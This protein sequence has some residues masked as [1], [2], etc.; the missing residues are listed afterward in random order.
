MTLENSS[1]FNAFF[2]TDTHATSV[3]Y[4]PNGG[5]SSNINVIF[6]NEFNLVDA[7]EV[8]VES[9]TPVVTCKS[10][11][12]PN[13]QQGDQFTINSVNYQ[14][15]IIRPDGTGITEIQLEKT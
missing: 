5:S 9:S 11:D 2:D 12:V 10:S 7:G 13:I 14:V 6:N 1:D 3:S 8:G 4:T 15:V